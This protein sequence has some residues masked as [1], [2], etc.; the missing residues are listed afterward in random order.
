MSFPVVGTGHGGCSDG[1]AKHDRSDRA[2]EGGSPSGPGSYHLLTRAKL[3][4]QARNVEDTK[5]PSQ[6]HARVVATPAFWS[7]INHEYHISTTTVSEDAK[8][9]CRLASH[10]LSV[11]NFEIEYAEH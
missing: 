1:V 10:H 11:L 6:T 9:C 3:L 2:A 8:R 7:N 4:D 5:N